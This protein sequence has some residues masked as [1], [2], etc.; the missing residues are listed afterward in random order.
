MLIQN[1][2]DVNPVAKDDFSVLFLYVS[3]LRFMRV[4]SISDEAGLLVQIENR[5]EK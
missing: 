5:M 2:A 4:H 1:G 3:D